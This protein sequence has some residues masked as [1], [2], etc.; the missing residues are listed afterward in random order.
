MGADH[1]RSHFLHLRV[2]RCNPLLVLLAVAS[3]DFAVE[4]RPKQ[5]RAMPYRQ[6]PRSM[7]SA[8]DALR[9]QKSSW[10]FGPPRLCRP[11]RQL[12]SDPTGRQGKNSL[13]GADQRL[14]H[15][16]HLRVSR[17]NPLLVL[18]RVASFDS[19][20]ED[21]RE[22]CRAMPY[23]QRPRPM[24]SAANALGC[25]KSSWAFDPPRLHRPSRQL[26]SDPR[27]RQDKD[28]LTGADQ[29]CSHFLN[30]RVNRCNPFLVLLAEAFADFREEHRPK[31]CRAMPYRQR[32]RSMASAPD[33]LGCHKNSLAFD[34]PRLRRPSRQLQS[35]PR[36]RQGKDRSLDRINDPAISSTFE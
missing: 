35:D 8:A 34:P 1:R 23:R 28:S 10:A 25:Q 7:A 36:G 4:H 24:A 30:L 19:A 32:P 14:N 3:A 6:R 27:G 17:C 33:S 21:R 20:E 26:Q 2:N 31:Q 12:Q 16:L 22:Q 29:R 15:F 9:C 18:L 11:S 5:C 13:R